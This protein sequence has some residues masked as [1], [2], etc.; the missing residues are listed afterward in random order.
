MSKKGRMLAA[1]KK[2][3]QKMNK[4]ENKM[5]YQHEADQKSPR[6]DRERAEHRTLQF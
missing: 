6:T 1:H 4:Q 3:V 2:K 5:Y